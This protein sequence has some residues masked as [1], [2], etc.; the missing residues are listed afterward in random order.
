[1][2]IQYLMYLRDSVGIDSVKMY[3]MS[4]QAKSIDDLRS[5]KAKD[6]R[7][8]QS[9]YAADRSYPGDKAFKDD[10]TVCFQLHHYR[11]NQQM[12]PL[13][14]KDIYNFCIYY[15]E[16]LATSF[17]STDNEDFDEE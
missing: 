16:L 3:E 14:G 8:I 13:N 6:L 7:N 2:T 10:S 4:Y 1:M 15:P 5:H 17:V 12:H 11:V 9:G